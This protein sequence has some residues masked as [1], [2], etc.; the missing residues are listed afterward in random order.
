MRQRQ[1]FGVQERLGRREG[2]DP[3]AF[4]RRLSVT[5][6]ITGPWQ[7]GGRSETDCD[8]MVQLDLDYVENWSIGVDLE[9]LIKTVVVVVGGRG[10][11]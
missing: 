11:C 9:I 10:A 3:E 7:V 8:R 5:P 6:G 2:L 1:P 4:A